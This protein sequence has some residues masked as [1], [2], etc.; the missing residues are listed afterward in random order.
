MAILHRVIVELDEALLYAASSGALQDVTSLIQRG[1][2]I[3]ARSNGGH[4]PLHLA[5]EN[6]HFAVAEFLVEQGAAT[7]TVDNQAISPASHVSC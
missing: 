7:D 2:N 6:G 3:D 5:V 1:A 4:T